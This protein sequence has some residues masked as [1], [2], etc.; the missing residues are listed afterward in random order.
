LGGSLLRESYWP[1]DEKSTDKFGETLWRLV[2][3]V[4]A[5][6]SIDTNLAPG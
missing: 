1:L 2:D 5:A 4:I 6:E 3:A